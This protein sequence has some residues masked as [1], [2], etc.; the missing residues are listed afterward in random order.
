MK[1]YIIIKL[2]FKINDRNKKNTPQKV[3]YFNKLFS[4]EAGDG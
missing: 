2:N 3:V 4:F 1:K